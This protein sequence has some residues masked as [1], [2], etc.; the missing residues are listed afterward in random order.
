M[1]APRPSPAQRRPFFGMCGECRHRWIV[2]YAPMDLRTA[3]RLMTGARC[4]MCGGS[5]VMIPAENDGSLIEAKET[6]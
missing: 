1:T 2:L 5:K 6:A 3:V 4:P